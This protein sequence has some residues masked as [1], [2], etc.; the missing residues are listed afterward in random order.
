M[1]R[2]REFYV[3]REEVELPDVVSKKMAAAFRQIQGTP[4][5][6]TA[7]VYGWRPRRFR[8]GAAAAACAA[9]LAAGVIT[10]AAAVYSHWG[11]GMSGALQAQPQQQKALEE[12]G[13]ALVFPG[14]EDI[15]DAPSVF[16]GEQS[17]SDALNVAPVTSNGITVCPRTM[18]AASDC[19]WIS[20]AVDGFSLEEGAEPGFET[21]DFHGFGDDLSGRISWFN[22]CFS[23]FDGIVS[24]GSGHPVSY[25]RADAD[26]PVVPRYT[27]ENGTMEFI[28][29]IS[30][31][32]DDSFLGRELH[33]TLSNLG[34]LER[35]A[36]Q[37]LA[38]G[39]W[40]FVIPLSGNDVYRTFTAAAAVG[41]TGITVKQLEISPVSLRAVLS[42][43]AG[44]DSEFV[45]NLAYPCGLRFKDGSVLPFLADGGG[46]SFTDDT[47]AE[48]R[49]MYP[50]DRV[51]DLDQVEAL[52]LPNPAEAGKPRGE[53][54]YYMV[55]VK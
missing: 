48:Y 47:R 4:E 25:D 54:S 23:F 15:D 42:V 51:V 33:I 19:I 3:F 6:Q 44:T 40:D 16:S 22:A 46:G 11:R 34:T 36:F 49:M 53:N 27:D 32:M 45:S 50:F 7:R 52:V 55:P 30:A 21:V 41:D 24:D 9:L 14:G 17:A 38:E 20:F 12:Q 13:I 10:T 26:G 43:P 37:K 28:V 5:K 2:N 1:M 35:A 8:R 18:V 31:D 29:Q 39:T